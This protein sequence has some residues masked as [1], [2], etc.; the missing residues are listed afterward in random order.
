MLVPVIRKYLH[1]QLV[2]DNPFGRPAQVQQHKYYLLKGMLGSVLRNLDKG[3]VDPE[4]MSRLIQTFV[5][6]TVLH[7]DTNA[8]EQFQE[9][10][11]MAPPAFVT[12]SPTQLCNLRCTGCYAASDHSTWAKLPYET[13]HR[14]LREIHDEWGA[15]FAVISGGEPLAYSDGGRGILDV[16][17]DFP[18]MFFLMYTNGTLITE[19]VARRMA[20]LGNITPSI[21][22]EGYQA[23][24][25]QRRGNGAW[26]KIQSGITHLK[27]A[28]V[29]FGIS[30]T[31]TRGNAGLLSGDK[32]Y[33]YYFQEVGASYLWIF[34]YMPIGRGVDTE[35]MPTPEQRLAMFRTWQRV[36]RSR[37]Y[38]VADF[39]NAGISADGCIAYGRPGGYVYIDWNGNIMP[40]VFVPYYKDNILDV[41]EQGGTLTEALFSDFFCQGREWQFQ[42]GY[43]GNGTTR[44]WLAP[45]SIRDH[46]RE[47]L[48]RIR[49]STNI[50]P[51]DENA[52]VALTDPDYQRKMKEYDEQYLALTNPIWKR[53]FLEAQESAET[54]V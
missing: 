41:Y 16:V 32:I 26:A 23:E 4:V 49:S 53:E 37:E 13:V 35:L 38:F 33:D 3:Y 11:G 42:Y 43:D 40:C 15:R 6:N 5:Q 29:P 18:N 50:M 8:L 12:I 36:V 14:I 54:P 31:G 19:R 52:A 25:E 7:E 45:C 10:Y 48:E 46:Y 44:N 2:H 47:H 20:E 51:E 39:W 9:R 30:I 1:Y 27:G 17:A 24:T 34:Q 28:G 22:V 21:S